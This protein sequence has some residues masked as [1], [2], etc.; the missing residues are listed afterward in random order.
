MKFSARC[1]VSAAVFRLLNWR[2][3][4][5]ANWLFAVAEPCPANY[6]PRLKSRGRARDCGR[7]KEKYAR[8]E[9]LCKL[10]PI[11]EGMQIFFLNEGQGGA[12]IMTAQQ[13]QI[14][15]KL[16][17]WHAFALLYQNKKNR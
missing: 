11:N 1:W 13:K 15:A 17:G 8:D 3:S 4:L 7:T 6:S 14:F 16:L 2:C 12:K 9:K 10:I 5:S